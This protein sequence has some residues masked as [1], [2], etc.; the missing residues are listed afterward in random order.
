MAHFAKVNHNSV[1]CS[2]VVVSNDV[3]VNDEGV[4]DEA[5]GQDFLAGLGMGDGWLQC[6]YNGSMR[7]NYPGIG[8]AYDEAR[9]AFIPPKPD[10][11]SWVLDEGTCLWVAPVPMPED[12]VYVWDETTTSWVGVE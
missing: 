6:S 7:K 1:V 4:E 3:I 11:P 8:Y 2:V 5:L 10:Y 12:G 9:D